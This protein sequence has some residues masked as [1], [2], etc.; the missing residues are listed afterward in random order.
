RSFLK[1]LRASW[2]ASSH[3]CGCRPTPSRILP[4]CSRAMR[5]TPSDADSSAW[6][7]KGMCPPHTERGRPE[8]SLARPAGVPAVMVLR[9]LGVGGPARHAVQRQA[10][11]AEV[12]VVGDL[13]PEPLR[14]LERPRRL[15]VGE[16]DFCGHQPLQLAPEDIDLDGPVLVGREVAHLP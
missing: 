2:T 12:L 8:A 15:R 13:A 3:P 14:R 6:T 5:R 9:V 4:S 16:L 7:R 10:L 11:V 1:R